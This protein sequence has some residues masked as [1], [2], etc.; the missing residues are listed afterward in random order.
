MQNYAYSRIKKFL[1]PILTAPSASREQSRTNSLR[2]R[3]LFRISIRA[4]TNN[5]ICGNGSGLRVAPVVISTL[6]LDK[7]AGTRKKVNN[8]L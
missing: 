4:Q 8:L 2:S 1:L 5:G 7:N 3:N 6:P